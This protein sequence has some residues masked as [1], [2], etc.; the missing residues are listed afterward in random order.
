MKKIIPNKTFLWTRAMGPL[1]GGKQYEFK[2]ALAD[3]M[4]ELGYATY[5][6]EQIEPQHQER[7]ITD[8]P[9][10]KKQPDAENKMVETSASENK[11]SHKKKSKNK[12]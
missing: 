10:H 4:V 1:E 9:E 12:A 3:K 6:H 8:A 11:T 5:A 2:K 7:P